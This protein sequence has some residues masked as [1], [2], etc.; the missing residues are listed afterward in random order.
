MKNTKESQFKNTKSRRGSYQIKAKNIA[1]LATYLAHVDNTPE[2]Q[3]IKSK[4]K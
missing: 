2:I 3:Y 1:A 4:I